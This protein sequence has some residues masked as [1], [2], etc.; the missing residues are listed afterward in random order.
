MFVGREVELADAA[1][2]LQAVAGGGTSALLVR[3]PT[4]IGKSAFCREVTGRAHE[5]GWRVVTVAATASGAPY[6]PIGAVIEQLLVHGRASLAALPPRTRSILAELSPLAGPAPALQ[7]ALTRHQVVAALQR[8]LALAAAGAPTVL[9]VE[10]AHLLDGATA[11]ALHQLVAG[12]GGDALLVMLA[13][14]AEWCERACH[15]A[16]PSSRAATVRCR[17]SS[18]RSMRA[19]SLSSSRSPPRCSRPR[20][21]CATPARLERNPFFA[22]ELTRALASGAAGPLPQTVRQAITQ[23]L[24]GLDPATIDA[25]TTLAIA[26]DELDLASV[27]ALTGLDE[28]NAFALLDAALTA[29]F[30]SWPE[31]TTGSATKW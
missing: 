20:R 24:V 5:R 21:P 17:S 26:E 18:A 11:D 16:S 8:A 9:C 3:G 30:S 25:L 7:G 15:A 28:R 12:A 29:G 27:L 23:R 4:G 13:S 19:R 1:R 10:D 2:Q 31:R 22:L 6:G 14:R